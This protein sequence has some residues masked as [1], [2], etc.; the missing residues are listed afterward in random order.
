V[1]LHHLKL[2][3]AIITQD[4][5]A[6]VDH[7][8]T[9]HEA[10]RT[11]DQ[12]ASTTRTRPHTPPGNPHVE[13]SSFTPD[14]QTDRFSDS[15]SDN[16]TESSTSEDSAADK[17]KEFEFSE[18][19]FHVPG[20]QRRRISSMRQSD[21]KN[22]LIKL[23]RK[24]GE[25]AAWI[26]RELQRTGVELSNANLKRQIQKEK[27]EFGIL[28]FDLMSGDDKDDI[29]AQKELFQKYAVTVKAMEDKIL[30]QKHEIEKMNVSSMNLDG[31][32]FLRKI[33]PC[34][35]KFVDGFEIV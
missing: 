19:R 5:M 22:P 23:K 2:G 1:L 14:V 3:G 8:G 18:D 24:F 29:V 6:V 10:N 15:E 34:E 35:R 7:V 13:T 27:R 26:E 21:E 20:V 16:M 17:D 28:M 32:A 25:S 9:Y 4:G 31:S 12:H 11:E 33:P 30:F